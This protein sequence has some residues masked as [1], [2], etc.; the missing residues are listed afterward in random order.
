MVCYKNSDGLARTARWTCP[1]VG[2]G[3]LCPFARGGADQGG[4]D[5]AAT[6]IL[7]VAALI[8]RYAVYI[9]GEVLS[10]NLLLSRIP[11]PPLLGKGAQTFQS[12]FCIQTSVVATPLPI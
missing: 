12:V 7:R 10:Y 2:E 9:E 11:G 4:G 1:V 8:H 3:R 5:A 6:T